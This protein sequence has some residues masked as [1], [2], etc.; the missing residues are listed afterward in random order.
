LSRR[1]PILYTFSFMPIETTSYGPISIMAFSST[2]ATDSLRIL[3]LFF[4][5]RVTQPLLYPVGNIFFTHGR[6][7][8]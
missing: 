1:I 4:H 8:V 3:A 2:C 7:S 6:K 5:E